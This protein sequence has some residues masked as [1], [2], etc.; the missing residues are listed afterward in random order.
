MTQEDGKREF[1][2]TLNLTENDNCKCNNDYEYERKRLLSTVNILAVTNSAFRF[3]IISALWLKLRP[4][5]FLTIR[6]SG[7]GLM[8]Q[9][10]FQSSTILVFGHLYSVILT[11]L[12]IDDVGGKEEKKVIY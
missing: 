12:V 8:D 9:F 4:S 5:G 7:C 10:G 11:F 3:I 1:F 6:P 2:L